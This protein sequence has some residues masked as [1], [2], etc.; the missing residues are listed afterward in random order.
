MNFHPAG[1]AA[2]LGERL[3]T[4]QE[5]AMGFSPSIVSDGA[6]A[7]DSTSPVVDDTAMRTATG[8]ATSTA[9]SAALATTTTEATTMHATLEHLSH[10]QAQSAAEPYLVRSTMKLNPDWPLGV[11]QDWQR[12][13]E[14]A[15]L[16]QVEIHLVE[17]ARQRLLDLWDAV[18]LIGADEIGDWALAADCKVTATSGQD[19]PTPLG[20]CAK[21]Y[22]DGT[23]DL[24][25]QFDGIDAPFWLDQQ[26]QL[27]EINS[28]AFG[29]G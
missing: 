6:Q 26:V 9:T 13:G 11:S 24:Y 23:V 22:A 27:E 7:P 20:V 15:A 12:L 2:R 28:K 18:L 4:F 3:A 29:H 25:V 16:L 5:I 10:S 21:V 1:N 17:A 19:A 8:T 14:L